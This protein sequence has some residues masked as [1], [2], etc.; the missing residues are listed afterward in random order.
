MNSKINQLKEVLSKYNPQN[1]RIRTEV[2]GRCRRCVERC[3]GDH[4]SLE[5][6]YRELRGVLNNIRKYGG[7]DRNDRLNCSKCGEKGHSKERCHNKLYYW[8]RLYLCG[9][10]GRKCKKLRS[11]AQS[12]GG[13]HCCTCQNPIAF[14]DAY[15]NYGIGKLK[16]EGCYEKISNKR[17]VSP[18]SEEENKRC[19]TETPEP[20]DPLEKLELNPKTPIQNKEES[21]CVN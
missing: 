7:I 10:D 20:E 14:S 6:E 21:E 17:P 8:N 19:K 12:K 18:E 11:E 1:F 2:N 15:T 5:I 16:C 4:Y 3:H 13:N 9:C